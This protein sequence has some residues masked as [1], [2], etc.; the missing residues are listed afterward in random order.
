MRWAASSGRKDAKA[1]GYQV[2]ASVSFPDSATDFGAAVEQA[3][4]SGAQIVLVD[5][6]TP[7]AISIRQQMA[8]DAYT[9][10]VLDME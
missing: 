9:P 10:K 1:N 2:V 4:S 3:K 7:Q 6:D 5:C 8:S